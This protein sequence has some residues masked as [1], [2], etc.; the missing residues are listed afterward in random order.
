ML[1]GRCAHCGTLRARY[2]A[3]W[4]A[5]W[6]H[7]DGYLRELTQEADTVAEVLTL[8]RECHESLGALT[9]I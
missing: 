6:P 7:S 9:V 8:M 2:K 3:T 1:R 4:F 5:D